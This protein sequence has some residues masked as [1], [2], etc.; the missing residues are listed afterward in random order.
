MLLPVLA[1]NPILIAAA[2]IPA[3]LLLKKIYQ[4]DHLDKEPTRL[5]VNLVVLGVVSTALAIV[6]ERLG[7]WI[8]SLVLFEDTIAYQFFLYFVVVAVSEEGFKYLLLRQ[9]TW[10]SPEFNCQFDA[11]VYATFV[12]L[13]FALWENISYVAS[14][15]LSTALVRAVTA[16][17]GHACF[18]V[19][20]GVFYGI[21]KKYENL[22]Q[23]GTS[24]TF[25][26]LSV[27]VPVL[28][29]GAY[30]F[31]A[32]VGTGGATTVFLVFVAVMFL[33]A[34]R[35]VVMMSRSD[36][37]IDNQPHYEDLWKF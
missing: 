20:M 24:R 36:Q 22:G 17:P 4:A 5:L 14:Y 19:F 18:G 6:A 33:A 16:V 3:V 2:V 37:Y 7:A 15:G 11:V 29:H 35:L 8:L 27:V 23:S 32:S 28:L 13:G 25:R 21:A 31:I 9:R 1:M 26:I 30:D 34:Y 12:S 10:K